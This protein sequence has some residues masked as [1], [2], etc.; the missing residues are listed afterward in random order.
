MDT[1]PLPPRPSLEQYRKR[2]KGLVDAAQSNDP[3]AVQEWAR[4]WLESLTKAL[5]VDPS[6]FVKGSIDRAVTHIDERV[7]RSRSDSST[8]A[9]ADAQYLI[10]EAHGFEN[11]GVFAHHLEALAGKKGWEDDFETAAD[12]VVNGDLGTLK[13]LVQSHPELIHAHSS[14]VHRATL[15]HYVA[16]NGVEDFRQKTPTNAVEIARFL[17]ESGAEVD[18]LADTY[19]AD[20]WQTTMN[21]LVSSTHPADAGLQPALVELLADYGAAVNGVRDDESPLLTALDF[22]YIAAAE[23]LVRR[24]ARV[25]NVITAA[26]MGRLDLV[27]RF[28]VDKETLAPGVP[29]I[30]PHWQKVPNEPKVHI[31][32]ALVWACKFAR[33]E[34]AEFLLQFGVDPTATDGVDMTPLHWAAGNGSVDLV[35]DLLARGASLE[36]MNRWEGTVLSSTAHFAIHFPAPGVDYPALLEMLIAAG[37]DPRA[38]Y[39]SGNEAIDELLRRHGASRS[40]AGGRD[41]G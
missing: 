4:R 27:Q 38:A 12:A 19:G 26:S 20:W 18:A 35:K 25:D 15:L 5:G 16:A 37:A 30:A 39:P 6:P 23:A 22:G 14:R 3:A 33:T 34:V 21:L 13:A 8:F 11:W 28:V 17:L 32:R 2:A 9:L 7:R 40:E 10:A 1:L 24:G 36:A 29:M 31:E 41:D